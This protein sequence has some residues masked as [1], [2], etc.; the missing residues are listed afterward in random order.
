MYKLTKISAIIPAYN[1]RS[2]IADIVSRTKAFANEIIVIDDCSSDATWE[3]ACEAGAR[4]IRNKKNLGY[5]NSIKIGLKSADG[6]VI[7]TLDADGEH[8]PEE[9][10]K[11]VSPLLN[12]E[13]D[14]VFGSREEICRISERFINWLAS[15]RVNIKDSSS[16][17]RAMK[18]DLA[19]KLGLKGRCTCGILA[20]EAHSLGARISEVPVAKGAESQKRKIA[21]QHVLQLAFVLKWLIRS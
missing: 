21:W 14:L 1:E 10:P 9:I 4:V 18:K 17:F 6:E 15:I 20:L 13:A 12:D 16:G 19:K 11:L 2:R 3:I 7:V 5:L 8:K